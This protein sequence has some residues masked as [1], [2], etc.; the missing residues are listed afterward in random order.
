[1]NGAIAVTGSMT[2][3]RSNCELVKV[4]SLAVLSPGD[5]TTP[6]VPGVHVIVEDDWSGARLGDGAG[7]DG[8]GDQPIS[9]A[10][11]TTTAATNA[12]TNQIGLK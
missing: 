8:L 11:I 12:N 5:R 10:P 7:A 1:M 4:M 6:I 2:T 9:V 3:S